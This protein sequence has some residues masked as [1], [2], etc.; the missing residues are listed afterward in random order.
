MLLIVSQRGG[1]NEY[2]SMIHTLCERVDDIL[3]AADLRTFVLDE[4]VPIDRWGTSIV[5]AWEHAEMTHRP[6]ILL[7]NLLY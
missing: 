6:V 3:D 7:V 1:L 4:R 2:N 5:G